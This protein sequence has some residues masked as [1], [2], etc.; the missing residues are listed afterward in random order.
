MTRH[1]AD[2]RGE[3]V[4]TYVCVRS[5][6]KADSSDHS[7]V[8]LIRC[9]CGRE[10]FMPL[11]R[12]RRYQKHNLYP[13]CF[14]SHYRAAAV[15]RGKRLPDSRPRRCSGCSGTDHRYADC[16]KRKPSKVC[17]RCASLSHRV[18][19]IRCFSCGLRFAPETPVA[20]DVDGAKGS[21]IALCAEVA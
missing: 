2:L 15:T 6:G 5:T 21:S 7:R 11:S 9:T 16:P 13:R 17:W 8:W 20:L 3:R 1:V 4:G 12:I 14:C 19:G 18:A 10:L